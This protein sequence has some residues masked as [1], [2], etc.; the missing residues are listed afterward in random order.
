MESWRRSNAGEQ[1]P[2][3]VQASINPPVVAFWAIIRIILGVTQ[4]TGAIVLAVCLY[5]YG[6]GRETM[7]ALFV[8]MGLTVLSILLFRVLRVQNKNRH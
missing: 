8:T 7:I 6:A 4:M 5:R 1:P 3:C 2:N